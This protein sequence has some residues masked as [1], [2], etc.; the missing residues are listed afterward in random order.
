MIFKMFVDEIF[1][2]KVFEG[3]VYFECLSYLVVVV[4]DFGII[5]SGFVFVFNYKEGNGWIYMV[6]GY[7]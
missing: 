6:C 2:F 4:I 3:L 1:F 5:F 7:D